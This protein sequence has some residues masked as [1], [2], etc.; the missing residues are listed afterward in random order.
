MRMTSLLAAPAVAI[1]I[2]LLAGS[3]QAA[4]AGNA[5]GGLKADTAAAA[6]KVHWRRGCYWH[7]GHWHCG[8][9]RYHQGYWGHRH[10]WHR[11]R[12]WW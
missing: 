5:L 9:H 10:R 4:P 8:G 6:E 12:H 11:H 2:G 3:A 7:R 1:A